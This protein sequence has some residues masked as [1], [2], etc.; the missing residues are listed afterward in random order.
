[1]A[2][3]RGYSSDEIL[4]RVKSASLAVQQGRGVFERDAV[5]FDHVQHAWPVLAGLLWIAQQ[6]RGSLHVLDF[7]GSLGSSYRQNRRFFSGLDSFHWSI[8]EQPRF[9]ECGREHFQDDV[10]HFF[11]SVDECLSFA[12]PDVVLF[13]SVLHYL[14]RPFETLD[15][16]L[17]KGFDFAIVDRTP[18][19]DGPR[20]RLCIQKTAR[21][22]Y[23]ASYPAWFFSHAHF[24][25]F[26]GTRYELIEQFDSLDRAHLVS[27]YLGFLFRRRCHTSGV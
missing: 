5:L 23:Q 13:S 18:F 16:I 22:I 9:V 27:R 14:Q 24:I 17:N 20:D 12:K 10:L 25:E 4:D 21:P 1:M 11:N 6:R 19:I 15:E 8:V 7:G 2:Q 3:C 26:W